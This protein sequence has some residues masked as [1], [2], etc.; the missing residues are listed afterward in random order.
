M[1]RRDGSIGAAAHHHPEYWTERDHDRFEDRVTRELSKLRSDVE[2][3]SAR[4]TLLLGAI[5]VIAFILPILAPLI[6]PLFGIP[7]L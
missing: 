5:A 6:R 7:P 2:R 1:T 3:L 4:V